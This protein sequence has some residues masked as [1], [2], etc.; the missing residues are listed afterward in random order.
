MLP[1]SVGFGNAGWQHCLRRATWNVEQKNSATELGI[2]ITDQDE[3]PSRKGHLSQGALVEVGR[4]RRRQRA[5]RQVHQDDGEAV[6]P[7]GVAVVAGQGQVAPAVAQVADNPAQVQAAPG[8]S[9]LLQIWKI[10]P[11]LL[12]LLLGQLFQ[13]LP[14]V[15][16]RSLPLACRTGRGTP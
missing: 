10:Q 13:L 2:G 14:T 4:R 3:P 5:R 15:A 1:S 6:R 8:L 11:L 12:L 7:G 16:N 9:H